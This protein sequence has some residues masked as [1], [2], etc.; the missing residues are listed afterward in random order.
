MR[1]LPA[2][3]LAYTKTERCGVDLLRVLPQRGLSPVLVPLSGYDLLDLVVSVVQRI[4][5]I[6]GLLMEV[7]HL[8]KDADS[9]LQG[10]L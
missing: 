1:Y 7:V 2:Q 9:W 10:Q 4:E 6:L 5:S 8:G 3:L